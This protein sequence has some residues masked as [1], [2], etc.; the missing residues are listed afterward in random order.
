MTKLL[1]VEDN[2]MNWDMLSRRLRRKGFEVVR[3]EDGEQGVEMAKTAEPDLI[4]M[5]MM[6]PVKDGYE[7]T[8]EI[9]AMPETHAIPIIGLTANAMEGDKAKVMEAGCDGYQ[10]KPVDLPELLNQMQSFLGEK[11]PA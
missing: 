8:R 4:L 2:D 6:M 11:W 1:M 10:S 3:A 5:D 7:A 9:K